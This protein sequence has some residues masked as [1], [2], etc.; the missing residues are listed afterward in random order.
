[1]TN[2]SLESTTTN[3]RQSQTTRSQG[4]FTV[5]TRTATYINPLSTG[6][7]IGSWLQKLTPPVIYNRCSPNYT[8]SSCLYPCPTVTPN[9]FQARDSSSAMEQ[10]YKVSDFFFFLVCYDCFSLIARIFGSPSFRRYTGSRTEKRWLMFVKSIAIFERKS[11]PYSYI[12]TNI[13]NMPN[14]YATRLAEAREQ[15][16]D[17]LLNADQFFYDALDTLSA[18][19]RGEGADEVAKLHKMVSPTNSFTQ[20]LC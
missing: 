15:L 7:D 9:M 19:K 16:D 18:A 4:C 12:I 6:M 8:T 11:N 3:T 1:M 5:T 10:S 14:N 17:L 20:C 13:L 2:I